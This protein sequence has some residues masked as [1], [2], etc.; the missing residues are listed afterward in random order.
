[1]ER[2]INFFDRIAFAA[3]ITMLFI[4]VVSVAARILFDVTGGGVN[5]MIPGAIELGSYSLLVLVFA[6][7]PR[8]AV[9]GLIS[10]DLL[11]GS[12]PRKLRIFL[13]KSWDLLLAAFAAVLVWLFTEETITMFSRGDSSQDLGIPLYLFYGL[14]SICS[15]CIMFTGLWLALRKRAD[16]S[17]RGI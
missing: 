7:L 4:V 2:V 14:I 10:V 13:E 12:L 17:Q 1:M 15:L 8:A 5:L 16:Q 6:S 11:I 3:L 9:S